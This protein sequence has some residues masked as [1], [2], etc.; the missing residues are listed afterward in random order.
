MW[1][2]SHTRVQG[3]LLHE[4]GHGKRLQ[5][6]FPNGR[7]SPQSLLG[8]DRCSCCC[9][10]KPAVCWQL[11]Q[12]RCHPVWPQEALQVSHSP[13]AHLQKQNKRFRS[14]WIKTHVPTVSAVCTCYRGG[15]QALLL[16]LRLIALG[17]LMLEQKV[18]GTILPSAFLLQPNLVYCFP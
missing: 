17:L 4:A 9:W 11:T 15:L 14:P 8:T 6:C 2:V 5:V 7:S 10:P 1:L 18:R 3:P 13:V 16:Q 12:R